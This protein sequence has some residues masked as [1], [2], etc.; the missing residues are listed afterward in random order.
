MQQATSPD[1]RRRAVWIVL[2]SVGIG[3]LPDADKYGDTGSNTLSH[4]ASAHGGLHLPNLQ[5]LG[6]GNLTEVEGVPPEPR[7][8]GAF[9]RMAERS[10]GKD[11]TTGH[12]EMTGVPL[13]RPF[14]TYPQGFPPEVI[15]AFTSA[16]G[17][18]ILGNRPASGTVIIQELGEEHL[19]TGKPIV[20]TSA[21]SVFQIA[22][23]EDVIPVEELY[24]YC[25]IAREI[26]T[27]PHAVGRVIARPFEGK[28]GA[29]RRT[30]RRRDFSLPP[31]K[32]TL[33]DRLDDAGWPVFAVG[34]IKDIFAGRG[35]R[36]DEHTGNNGETMA[37]TLKAMASW[38][39]GLIMANC[40]DFDM[41]Y[42]HRNDSEG[43]AAA[44]EAV[45]LQI[46]QVM[47]AMGP[48][49]L[50]II[51]ADH[52]CD[53]TTPSTDHSREYVPALLYGTG[54]RPGSSFGTRPTFAD[55]GATVAEWFGLPPGEAG[56]SFLADIQ[57]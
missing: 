46:G 56:E 24:R 4:V 53:P 38:E 20:Y 32:P 29:F 43:Y 55:L 19:R 50:L 22:C 5:K 54:I 52:G 16:I 11:T 31:P 28:P 34:K 48:Q 21:D 14:P 27:G 9:G 18:G 45:D 39:R 57:S 10:P 49:D 3:E 51:T 33:L 44:L 41:L 26:L 17:R 30:E 2:D 7:P 13:D 36:A 40:V 8:A 6:I 15:K 47:A 23:H 12:W 35:I 37:V 42:G 25:Q 1:R